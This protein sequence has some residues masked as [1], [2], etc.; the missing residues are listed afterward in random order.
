MAAE[1]FA[2]SLQL[3]SGPNKLEGYITLDW[4]SLPGLNILAYWAH[5]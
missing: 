3:L 1:T 5:L 2:F 4:K